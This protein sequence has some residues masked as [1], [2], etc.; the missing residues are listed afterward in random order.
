[1]GGGG[2]AGRR[3][4]GGDL[5][6]CSSDLLLTLCEQSRCPWPDGEGCTSK[7]CCL[8]VGCITRLEITVPVGWALNT[9]N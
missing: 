7:M 4:E 1:M 8:L 2:A 9:N 5:H 3:G 6:L